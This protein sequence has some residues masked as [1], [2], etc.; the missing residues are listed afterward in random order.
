M[1][2][3]VNKQELLLLMLIRN[4]PQYMLGD[5]AQAG[6]CCSVENATITAF[7]IQHDEELSGSRGSEAWVMN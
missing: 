6:I 5:E 1:S 3:L 2:M 4:Y 7:Q